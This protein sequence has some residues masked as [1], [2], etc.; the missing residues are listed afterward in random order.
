MFKEIYTELLPY[1][2]FLMVLGPFFLFAFKDKYWANLYKY[3]HPLTKPFFDQ[4]EK[5]AEEEVAR[6]YNEKSKRFDVFLLIIAAIG[7]CLIG[8]WIVLYGY[9]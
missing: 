4:S 5:E 7:L 1:I 3:R 8:L 9:A 2:F 6:K